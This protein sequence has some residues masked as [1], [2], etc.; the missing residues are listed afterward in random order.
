MELAN[1]QNNIAANTDAMIPLISYN[2]V[3]YL[4]QNNELIWKLLKYQTPD[5]WEKT[6]LTSSEKATMIYRGGD[7]DTMYNY[8]VFFDDF[9][10]DGITK[11]T[12]FLRIFPMEDSPRNHLVSDVAICMVVYTH[13]NCNHLSNY[14]TRVE[15]II[16]Q[17]KEMFNGKEIPKLG[18]LKY[19]QQAS[20]FCKSMIIGKV[21]YKGKMVIFHALSSSVKEGS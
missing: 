11:E 5:A 1:N 19:S 6:N 15:T 16:Q 9:Q 14:Q 18:M 4:L 12:T 8:N 10:D 17:L 20:R 21:P 3:A 2:C 7:P 13:S